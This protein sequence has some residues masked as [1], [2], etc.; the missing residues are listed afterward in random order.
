MC[1]QFEQIIQQQHAAGFEHLFKGIPFTL[2]ERGNIRPT[3]LALTIDAHGARERSWSLIPAWA[4]ESRL[5]FATFNARAE[6]ITSKPAFRQA[7][8]KSQR[9]I[10]PASAYSEWPSVNGQKQR[11]RVQSGDGQP[12]WFAGLW[13]V[14][15]QADEEK[16]SFTI[17]TVPPLPQIEWLHHRMPLMLS[18]EA[19]DD[20][21]HAAPEACER[22]LKPQA[23]GAL[24]VLP[25]T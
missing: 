14:W 7:W 6:T 16:H 10:V 1:S 3:T 21:L 8:A 18:T 23:A 20:W 9:C 4:K 15:R 22:H 12:L 13:E 17:L 19:V 5:K 24:R 11:H 2:L 25:V